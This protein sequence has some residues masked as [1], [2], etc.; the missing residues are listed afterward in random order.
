MVQT[1]FRLNSYLKTV[2][3]SEKYFKKVFYINNFE[4]KSMFLVWSNIKNYICISQLSYI[5]TN[6]SISTNDWI[7]TFFLFFKYN[8]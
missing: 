2:L 3:C 7:S 5:N 1:I 4:K 8:S 6:V